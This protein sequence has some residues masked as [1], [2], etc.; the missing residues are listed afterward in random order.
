MHEVLLIGAGDERRVHHMPSGWHEVRREHLPALVVARSMAYADEHPRWLQEPGP[1]NAPKPPF[2]LRGTHAGIR[3]ELFRQLA[4]LS[5]E[6]VE[7]LPPVDDLTFRH[8]EGPRTFWLPLP[9]LNWA[10]AAPSYEKS[11]MPT[12]E[13][14]GRT[15]RGPDDHLNLLTCDQWMW[16]DTLLNN[17][18]GTEE[19]K[20]REEAFH[21]ALAALYQPEDQLQPDPGTGTPRW[22]W[23]S[24]HIEQLALQLRALPLAEKYSAVLNYEALRSVLPAQYPRV[25]AGGGGATPPGGLFYVANK[26]AE[27][28][29]MGTDLMVKGRRAHDILLYMEQRLFD[30]EREAEAAR[31]ASK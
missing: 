10:F 2:K 21:H 3:L 6:D 19:P 23:S 9:Q 7:R 5:A 15:W 28:G 24:E 4:G 25:F 16:V 1:R 14:N 29:V 12:L 13:V 11:L 31:K 8:E 27:R 22:T 17:Y 26:V 18:Q 20:A 30:D